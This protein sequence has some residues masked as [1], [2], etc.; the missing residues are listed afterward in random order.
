MLGATSYNPRIQ[1]QLPF[2]MTEPR[3]PFP[4]PSSAYWKGPDALMSYDEAVRRFNAQSDKEK[5]MM[6]NPVQSANKPSPTRTGHP[7]PP[8]SSIYWK[9]SN[10]TYD[11]AVADYQKKHNI[12]PSDSPDGGASSSG[13]SDN[14]PQPQANGN[15]GATS[16]DSTNNGST[17]HTHDDS[18]HHQNGHT[19]SE[20]NGAPTATPTPEPSPPPT[21]LKSELLCHS[22]TLNHLAKTRSG[23]YRAGTKGS[24]V[25]LVQQALQ[26]LAFDLKANGYFD[27]TTKQQVLLFQKAYTPSHTTHPSYTMGPADGVVGRKTLFALDEALLD[28][29]QYSFSSSSQPQPTGNDSDEMDIKW[30]KVPKGQLTFDAEGDDFPHSPYF[31]RRASVPHNGDKV[32]GSSGVTIGKGLDLGSPPSGANGQRP[33]ALDLSALFEKA[34]LNPRLASWLLSVKGKQKQAALDSLTAVLKKG[35]LTER[36]LVITRKQ[37]YIMFNMTYQFME[38]KT[39]ILMTKEDVKRA[40]GTVDWGRLPR[41]VKD[42]LIDLTYRGDSYKATRSRYVPA[43]VYDQEH[44][45]SGGSSRF[46]HI[47]SELFWTSKNAGVDKNRFTNRRN[48]LL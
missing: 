13:N 40:Y 4:P 25:K 30:L 16:K 23:V 38:E 9:S 47:M 31:T 1:F 43:V 19:D 39:R 12:Q 29:W 20:S 27:E 10:T 6:C 42:V 8:P 3:Y 41:K 33:N 48:R 22:E 36:E 32:V 35:V 21:L 24:A 45:L 34:G 11:K 18:N 28:S 14:P 17:G 2:V 37:Q 26:K 15:G 46:Y 7:L 44:K 5:E